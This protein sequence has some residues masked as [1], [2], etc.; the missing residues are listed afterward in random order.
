MS[1]TSSRPRYVFS[2]AAISYNFLN[3]LHASKL[4]IAK[5]TFIIGDIMIKIPYEY[6]R[7]RLKVLMRKKGYPALLVSHAI[8][9]FYLSGFELHDPQYNESTGFL[10][11]QA[12]G[13]DWLLTDPRYTQA[14]LRLW[15]E[16]QLF[17]ATGTKKKQIRNF[18]K[19][20]VT[21]SLAIES[22]YLCVEIFNYLA[23]ALPLVATTG[24]VETLRMVKDSSELASIEHS[25]RLNTALMEATPDLLMPGMTEKETAWTIEHYFREHGASGL[26][27][28]SIVAVGPNAAMPHAIP[29]EDRILDNGPVLVDVGCRLDD[30][31]SDQTRTFW[32]GPRPS[33]DFLR[34]CYRVKTAQI[35]VIADLRPGLPIARAYHIARTYFEDENVAEHF[36]HALGHGIGL[37]THEPPTLSPLAEGI[38]QAGMVITVEPGLYYPEWGGVR[39]EYMVAITEDGA[40]VL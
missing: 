8:N 27:F 2:F 4:D 14:A 34:T 17:I 6:R 24:L 21:S 26:A 7:E 15:P 32:V 18:L 23:E 38:F 9:R 33:D 20:Y 28:N 37:E 29:G 10:L 19:A 1:Y 12:K 5:K 40:Q 13:Q 35:K 16:E 30:Y 25:C 11:I 36:V 31:C 39:W 3:V 22:H